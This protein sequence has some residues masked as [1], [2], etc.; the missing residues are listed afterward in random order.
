MHLLKSFYSLSIRSLLW[1]FFFYNTH[2]L[3][4]QFHLYNVL[5]KM[6]YILKILINLSLFFIYCNFVVQFQMCVEVYH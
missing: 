2:G 4:F 5:K 3:S 6:H 1:G